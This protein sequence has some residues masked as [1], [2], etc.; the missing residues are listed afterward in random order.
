MV[1][2]IGGRRAAAAAAAV[3]A[4]AGVVPFVGRA[5]A[6]AGVEIRGSAFVPSEVHVGV[7]DGEAFVIGD[8]SSSSTG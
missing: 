3:A 6:S 7:G 5:A 4:I 1:G 8:A 2:I